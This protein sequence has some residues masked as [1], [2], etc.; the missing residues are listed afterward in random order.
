MVCLRGT[1]ARPDALIAT[2]MCHLETI[3]GTLPGRS[4]RTRALRDARCWPRCGPA[5]SG[6]AVPSARDGDELRL[7]AFPEL[8][9]RADLGRRRRVIQ[10]RQAQAAL[11]V[12]NARDR[13]IERAP[14]AVFAIPFE[15]R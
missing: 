15:T 8:H 5:V 3:G 9:E 14:R 12:Q 7:K 6:A 1:G 11:H 13:G 10:D 2:A 4:D